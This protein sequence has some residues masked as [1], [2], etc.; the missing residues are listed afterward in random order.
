MQLEKLVGMLIICEQVLQNDKRNYRGK[1]FSL[2]T[3]H[4]S[5][6]VEPT[7]APKID[8]HTSNKSESDEYLEFLTQ[9]FKRMCKNKRN[10]VK[11]IR[12]GRE[13]KE[14]LIYY[15]SKKPGHLKLEYPEQT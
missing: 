12:A 13:N 10:F 4:K 7:K 3:S 11:D 15:G 14:K 1:S 6:R 2:K 5:R 8:D 9:R